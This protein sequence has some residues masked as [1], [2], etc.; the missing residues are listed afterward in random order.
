MYVD[1]L[2]AL[3]A[4]KARAKHHLQRRNGVAHPAIASSGKIKTNKLN[5]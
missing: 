2:S 1:G 3:V 4:L 5:G